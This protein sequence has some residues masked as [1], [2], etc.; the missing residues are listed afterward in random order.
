VLH[1]GVDQRSHDLSA[2]R[3]VEKCDIR[4]GNGG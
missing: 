2:N 1:S 3:L 4:C